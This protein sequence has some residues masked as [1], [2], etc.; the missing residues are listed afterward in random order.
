[1]NVEV[2]Q[3]KHELKSELVGYSV[4]DSHILKCREC[5]AKLAEIIKVET[6][7]SRKNRGLKPQKIKYSA[8]CYKCKS[9][10][11]ETPI[12]DGSTF[13]GV[14][15]DLVKISDSDTDIIGDTIVTNLIIKEK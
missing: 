1:M 5:G 12:I 15:S 4:L 10:S 13:A 11:F 2:E 3:T 7:E 8:S 14:L 9:S 6:N